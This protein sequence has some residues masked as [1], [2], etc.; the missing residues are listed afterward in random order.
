MSMESNETN[1]TEHE[2]QFLERSTHPP[3]K[4]KEEE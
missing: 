3:D 1:Y 4:P 2:R